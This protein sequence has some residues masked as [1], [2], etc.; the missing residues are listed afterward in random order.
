MLVKK[1]RKIKKLKGY[2]N[3]E[4]CAGYKDSIEKIYIRVIQVVDRHST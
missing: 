3:Y 1:V 2:T 4:D